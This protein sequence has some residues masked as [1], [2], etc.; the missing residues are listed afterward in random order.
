MSSAFERLVASYASIDALV[1]ALG[2]HGLDATALPSRENETAFMRVL[3]DFVMSLS[4]RKLR[5]LAAQAAEAARSETSTPLDEDGPPRLLEA[6]GETGLLP[7]EKSPTGASMGFRPA[8]AARAEPEP[9]GAGPTDATA[10]RRIGRRR[11]PDDDDDDADSDAASAFRTLDLSAFDETKRAQRAAIARERL[12]RSTEA[13]EDLSGRAIALTP[14]W[15]MRVRPFEDLLPVPAAQ[16][17]DVLADVRYFE[18]APQVA[19]LHPVLAHAVDSPAERMLVSQLAATQQFVRNMLFLL[20]DLRER[21]DRFV[22]Y[23]PNLGSL[24]DAAML[25]T[26]SFAADRVADL[27]G[28]L[29]AKCHSRDPMGIQ[30]YLSA[31]D[32]MERRN[33]PRMV[34]SSLRGFGSLDELRQA[35]FVGQ[36]REGGGSKKG[37]RQGGGAPAARA[38]SPVATAQRENPASPSREQRSPHKDNRGRG[39]GGGR[40]GAAATTPNRD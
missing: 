20:N 29:Y 28:H 5:A 38:K 2:P 27:R 11:G 14:T 36:R 30:A 34:G 19:P 31:M 6:R 18:G 12:L 39:N 23:D 13:S 7:R 35:G 22:D 10:S 25:A 1:E 32:S 8:A 9:V 15:S 3:R 40:G 4:D 21:A 16:L 37:R 17:R 24:A 26:T 33:A